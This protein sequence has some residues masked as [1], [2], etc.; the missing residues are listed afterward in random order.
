MRVLV[1]GHEGSVGAEQLYA[2]YRAHGL[3]AADRYVRLRH[4][5]RMRD[6]MRL[7][8]ALRWASFGPPPPSPHRVS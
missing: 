7:D 2:A 6:E 3:T 4:V 1:T 8:A 5:R